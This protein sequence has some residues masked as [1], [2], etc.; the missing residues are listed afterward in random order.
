MRIPY[1]L[2]MSLVIAGIAALPIPAAVVAHATPN[3]SSDA[4]SGWPDSLYF[5]IAL[6]ASASDPFVNSGPVTGSTTDIYL[7]LVCEESGTFDDFTVFELA[8][9]PPPGVVNLGYEPMAGLNAGD[10][11]H[12]LQAI[13]CCPTWPLVVGVWHVANP[14]AGSY[15]IVPAPNGAFTVWVDCNDQWGRP[16]QVR[17]IGYAAGGGT[18]TCIQTEG[19]ACGPTSVEP[20]SWGRLKTLYR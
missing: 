20:T 3:E 12:I 19:F 4:R 16:A 6:S 18:A 5:D 2:T 15:C 17:Q 9:A 1:S 7:W 8:F 14:V 11:T 10:D 13:C